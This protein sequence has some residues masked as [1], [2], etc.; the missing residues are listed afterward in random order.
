MK[1]RAFLL[2]PVASLAL[3][4]CGPDE[5]GDNDG[6]N[7]DQYERPEEA[8]AIIS[9]AQLS[10]LVD[11]GATINAGST[12]PQLAGVYDRANGDV[13]DADNEASLSLDPCNSIWT[14][15]ET[16]A[17]DTFSTV[18]EQ[19][20][21]CSGTIESPATYLAGSGDCFSLYVENETELDG[22]E[23]RWAQVISG[24]V[25]DAGI[26]DYQEADLG[27]ENDGSQACQ[28]LIDGG[29]IPGEGQRV[30]VEYGTVARE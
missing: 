17:E 11:F 12:P 6:N 10:D 28:D 26:S 15:E 29:N 2:I 18:A 1:Y 8:R 24:C 19:Y 7:D 21:D 22:C 20:G 14:V 9:D 16:D 30:L 13:V 3:F 23:V 4:G 27:L 25:D 5:T